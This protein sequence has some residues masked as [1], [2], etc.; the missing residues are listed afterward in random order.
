MSLR[1]CG[2]ENQ[3]VADDVALAVGRTFFHFAQ[4]AIAAAATVLADALGDDAALG[5]RG[6]VDHLGTGVLM[7]ALRGKRDRQNLAAG[8]RLHHVDGRVLHRQ[9]AT[10]VAVDPLHERILIGHGP[11]GHQ[12][13]DVVGP[14]LD[15]RVAAATILLDDHFDHGRVQALGGVHRGGAAFDVVDLGPFVDDDQRPLELAHLL[16]IDAE[17]GLQR[18][19]DLHARGHVDER[20]TRPDG[21]VEGGKL[22]VRAAE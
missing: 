18:E 13:V 3:G 6:T 9:M 10:Q 19:L 5:M 11:F 20:T 8:T 22:V 17:I 15:R 7:L 4:T 14:V 16:G 21:R 2:V 12:V 1:L